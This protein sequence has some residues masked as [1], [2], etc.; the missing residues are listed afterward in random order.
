MRFDALTK[1]FPEEAKI[2]FEV[3][4]ENAEWRYNQYRKLA[5]IGDKAY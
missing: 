3:T 5:K 1:T 2:L 4:Q